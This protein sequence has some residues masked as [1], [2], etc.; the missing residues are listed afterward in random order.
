MK[1][2]SSKTEDLLETGM[3]DGVKAMR[4]YLSYEGSDKRYLERAKVG[5]ALAS[6]WVKARASES[7]RM[8]VELIATR[9]VSLEPKQ[10]SE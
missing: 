3:S 8:Q 5:A 2:L 7:N 6:A 1:P 10:L 9:V 4:A